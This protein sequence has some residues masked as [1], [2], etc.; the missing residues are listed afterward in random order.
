MEPIEIDLSNDG[1]FALEEFRKRGIGK[2]KSSPF[3]DGLQDL[4]VKDWVKLLLFSEK[5][6]EAVKTPLMKKLFVFWKRT[7][8]QLA[9]GCDWEPYTYGPYSREIELALEE[10]VEKGELELRIKGTAKVYRLKDIEYT[11]K[12]A[13]ALP[14]PIKEL[15]AEVIEDF[16]KMGTKEIKE[17]VYAAYPKYAVKAAR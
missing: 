7:N 16:S 5:H 11:S 17:Y 8:Q 12:L 13:E 10:L 3:V 14:K 15:L 2:F 4:T 1:L 9:I 6:S